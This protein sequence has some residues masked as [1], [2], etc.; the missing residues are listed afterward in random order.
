M[1]TYGESLKDIRCEGWTSKR[2][3]WTGSQ[4]RKVARRKRADKKLMH[5]RARRLARLG[6][7]R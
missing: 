6:V 7:N 3:G 4:S 5:R 1:K 2:T